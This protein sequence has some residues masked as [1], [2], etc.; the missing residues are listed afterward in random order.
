M[1]LPL[2]A[3]L[4]PSADE[5]PAVSDASALSNS[6]TTGKILLIDDHA[7]TLWS[8]NRLL[9]HRGYEVITAGSCAE[10]LRCASQ[11]EYDFIISDLGLPD[12]SGLDL[13]KDMRRHSN[14][15]A[16][17]LSGYGMESDVALTR[18]AG[19]TTHLTKP[20]DFPALIEV[21]RALTKR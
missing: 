12:G 9:V 1:R 15:P 17:A 5:L 4:N 16:I 19:F 18:E 11:G 14:A 21:L 3:T 13:L 6:P 7:D 2:S 10:A 20:V 8:M